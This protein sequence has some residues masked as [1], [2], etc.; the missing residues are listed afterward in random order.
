MFNLK[1]STKFHTHKNFSTENLTIIW[2]NTSLRYKKVKTHLFFK[3]NVHFSLKKK[4][5]S[6]TIVLGID[7]TM[8]SII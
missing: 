5:K 3:I 2:Q 1:L 7:L 6:L 8:Y 4:K